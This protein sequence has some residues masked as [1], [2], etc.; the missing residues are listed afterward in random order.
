[1]TIREASFELFSELRNNREVVGSGV[2]KND[3]AYYIIIYLTA[4]TQS[5]LKKIPREYHGNLVKTE[6]SGRFSI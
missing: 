1:M 6:I 5:I 3:N 2:R 4:A